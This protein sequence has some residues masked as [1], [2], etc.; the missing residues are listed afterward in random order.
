M[1]EL[2]IGGIGIEK[3]HRD[4]FPMLL[5]LLFYGAEKVSTSTP[6]MITSI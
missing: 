3:Q 1:T 6:S 5:Y 2:K 4:V